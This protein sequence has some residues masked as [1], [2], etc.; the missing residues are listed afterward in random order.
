MGHLARK[1]TFKIIIC[2]LFI[3]AS[4]MM[5]GSLTREIGRDHR[6]DLSNY[7]ITAEELEG[8]EAVLRLT[9]RVADKVS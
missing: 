3:F 9:E 2:H 1:Q 6:P 7:N 4:V 5:Y 8:L